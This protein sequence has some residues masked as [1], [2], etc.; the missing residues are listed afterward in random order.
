MKIL[1]LIRKQ[2]RE[3]GYIYIAYLT[4]QDIESEMRKIGRANKK[5]LVKECLEREIKIPNFRREGI[6]KI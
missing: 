5:S 4:G 6:N 3:T 1:D 2:K